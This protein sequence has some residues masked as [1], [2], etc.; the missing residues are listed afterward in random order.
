MNEIQPASFVLVLYVSLGYQ[1]PKEQKAPN[2][3]E[4]LEVA[5]NSSMI[6]CTNTKQ[7]C[8]AISFKF[9]GHCL[10]LERNSVAK[11]VFFL[12]K[13]GKPIHTFCTKARHSLPAQ[14]T[15]RDR[16]KLI[17]TSEN[18]NANLIWVALLSLAKVNVTVFGAFL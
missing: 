1:C 7:Y 18:H 2:A 8:S 17:I 12:F 4:G 3:A 10:A 9:P 5:Q 13:H 14:E 15:V 16:F 6:L 11:I